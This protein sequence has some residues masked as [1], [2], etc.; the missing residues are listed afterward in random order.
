MSRAGEQ[1]LTVSTVG[2]RQRLSARTKLQLI[3]IT[4]INTDIVLGDE[5]SLNA[6]G[7]DVCYILHAHYLFKI[8]E[9]FL[10]SRKLNIIL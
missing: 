1:K 7:D 4:I 6:L 2:T 3:T 8:I 10:I 5:F 9:Y